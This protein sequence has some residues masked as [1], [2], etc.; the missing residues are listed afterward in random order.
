M[1]KKDYIAI[2]GVLNNYKNKMPMDIF[3][4]LVQ[5]FSAVFKK[6]NPRFDDAR[7]CAACVFID[8]E[9]IMKRRSIINRVLPEVNTKDWVDY[10]K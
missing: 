3:A 1:T 5:S 2:A 9:A 10:Y 8:N 6:D 4:E 7:F